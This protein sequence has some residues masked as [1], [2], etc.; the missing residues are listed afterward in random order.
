M[1]LAQRT[2]YTK[3]LLEK[4]GLKLQQ[5]WEPLDIPKLVGPILQGVNPAVHSLAL[6]LLLS[7]PGSPSGQWVRIKICGRRKSRAGKD[8]AEQARSNIS[9]VLRGKQSGSVVDFQCSA[10]DLGT[11]H[12]GLHSEVLRGAGGLLFVANEDEIALT[13]CARLHSLVQTVPEG[14][15]VPLLV[16]STRSKLAETREG[17]LSSQEELWQQLKLGDLSTSRTSNYR[18]VFIAENS[19]SS[20][21]SNVYFS[22]EALREGMLWLAAQCPIQPQLRS[23]RVA[24]LVR[25]H[26]DTG[27]KHLLRL[28]LSEVDPDRCISLFNQGIRHSAE[29]IAGI[30]SSSPK[31]SSPSS[32]TDQENFSGKADEGIRRMQGRSSQE[33]LAALFT[34]L[35]S[36]A[37]PPFP[38]FKPVQ[39]FGNINLQKLGFEHI[40][41]QFLNVVEGNSSDNLAV[42]WEVTR[43]VQR[44][45]TAEWS[46][47]GLKLVPKWAQ[48]FRAIFAARLLLLSI[49]PWPLVYIARMNKT[50]LLDA[51]ENETGSDFSGDAHLLLDDM[52]GR[53]LRRPVPEDRQTVSP[54]EETG[55]EV[56]WSPP[57][58][59]ENASH[60]TFDGLPGVHSRVQS[61]GATDVRTLFEPIAALEKYKGY[62]LPQDSHFEW[63]VERDEVS[64][65]KRLTL[66]CTESEYFLDKM[67]AEVGRL[68]HS[69][70]KDIYKRPFRSL[71]CRLH[72]H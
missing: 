66:A 17:D 56:E 29:E 38:P 14:A 7:T 63:L 50:T 26:L 67:L 51:D 48:V 10:E 62:R 37:L 5:M 4:Q 35:N 41:L 43:L 60:L 47:S 32:F 59:V 33:T 9:I 71:A 49:K 65:A 40:L 69:T 55:S 61:T 23:L 21:G 25:E 70:A 46:E 72:G 8:F 1:S 30:A 39:N 42:K 52:I 68:G 18:V 54:S 58:H 16:L 36:F 20:T 3:T 34:N 12:A 24:D 44:G 27:L 45:C 13:E 2:E 31:G 64:Q 22:D 15:K 57:P 6:R 19:M 53:E 28:P 11:A